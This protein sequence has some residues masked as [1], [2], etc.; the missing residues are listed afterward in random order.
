MYNKELRAGEYNKAS[1]KSLWFRPLK[2]EAEGSN[3]FFHVSK[4]AS[5]QAMK[6]HR[7][8]FYPA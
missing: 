2:T 5:R 4:D 3:A 1:S 7:I 6:S 8:L